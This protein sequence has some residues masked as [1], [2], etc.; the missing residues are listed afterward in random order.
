M[1]QEKR[2]KVAVFQ[3]VLPAYRTGFLRYL[4][5]VTDLIVYY[6]TAT[7]IKNIQATPGDTQGFSSVLLRRTSTRSGLFS[8]HPELFQ[9]LKKTPPDVI[10]AE[11]RLGILTAWAL[12][13]SPV[14]RSKLIWWLSGHQPGEGSWKSRIRIWIRKILYQRA[15]AYMAYGSATRRYLQGMGIDKNVFIAYNSL[16]TREIEGAIKNWHLRPD[17]QSAQNEVRAG[18]DIVLLFM[19]RFTREK[20]IPLL[21]DVLEHLQRKNQSLNI[22][23]VLMGDGPMYQDIE[24]QVISKGLNNKVLMTRAINNVERS[25]PYFLSAD[26]FILPGKGGLA[27]NQAIHF[28]LPVVLFQADGTEKDMVEDGVNGFYAKTQD[29]EGFVQALMPLLQDAALRKKMGEK[30]KRIASER[31]NMENM[32]KGFLDA[33]NSLVQVPD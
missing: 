30:S 19:G 25:A 4:G 23:L 2:I 29:R 33:I 9:H 6:S 32:R 3:E 10:I 20:N 31:S 7:S 5:E 8:W 18:A 12:A 21:L 13:Y 15:R 27:I 11:P 22:R 28:G 14:Y 17:L 16:D 1:E 24:R 26:L